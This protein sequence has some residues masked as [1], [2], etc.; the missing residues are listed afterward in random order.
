MADIKLLAFLLRTSFPVQLS[1]VHSQTLP[2]MLYKPN[3][4]GGK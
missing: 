2:A 4:F 3:L 1:C